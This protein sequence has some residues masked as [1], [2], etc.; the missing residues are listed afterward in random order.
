[1]RI[2]MDI[3]YLQAIFIAVVISIVFSRNKKIDLF[4]LIAVGT[5]LVGVCAIYYRY[6]S[7]QGS[8]Y[9]NDQD[10]HLLFINGYIENEGF[11]FGSIIPLRYLITYP[12]FLLSKVGFSEILILKTIQILSFI[13]IYFKSK[14]ILSSQ[15]F[16]FKYWYF[17][18]IASPLILFFSFLALRDLT[19][20]LLTI[21]FVFESKF[22]RRAVFALLIFLLK[23]HLAIALLFGILALFLFRMLR[24]KFDLFASILFL[25][26]SYFLGSVSYSVGAYFKDSFFP[27]LPIGLLTQAKI[28]QLTL[29]FSGLQFFSLIND[30]GSVVA[31]SVGFLLLARILLF[32]T[33]L[34]PITFVVVC[35]FFLRRLRG[36][37][38]V[39]LTSFVFYLGLVSQTDFNSTRQNIPFLAAMGIVAVV[40]IEAAKNNRR[41]NLLSHHEQ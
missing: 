25:V 41:E 3:Y 33:F 18:F 15:G 11:N 36:A 8:F 30:K 22:Q 6:G 7:D 9:S 19:L 12:T 23:P 40:N 2:A 14:K 26:A 35:V 17:A 31:E 24:T 16:P 5:W 4:P 20:A 34:I 29:N 10:V 37:A 27:G 38:F 13:G 32:D 28:S 21:S 1:M 39:I